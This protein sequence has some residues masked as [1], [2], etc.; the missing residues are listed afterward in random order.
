MA[1]VIAETT[2]SIHYEYL[3]IG[4]H[5]HVAPPSD[6]DHTAGLPSSGWSSK[7]LSQCSSREGWGH[8]L[9]A[10]LC[11]GTK[12]HPQSVHIKPFHFTKEASRIV[13]Q[14]VRQLW[15]PRM[16][17][18]HINGRIFCLVPGEVP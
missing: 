7:T 15:S 1:A 5:I 13:S 18:D 14:Q 2:E 4:L 11:P 3:L 10:A 6:A 17:Y 16:N 12:A 8:L 9:F